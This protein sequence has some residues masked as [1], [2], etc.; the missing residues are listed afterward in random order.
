MGNALS[1]LNQQ[2]QES[3]ICSPGVKRAVEFYRDGSNRVI[4]VSCWSDGSNT[5]CVTE[6]KQEEH[7]E[8]VC[9]NTIESGGEELFDTWQRLLTSPEVGYKAR[10]IN[11]EE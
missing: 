6:V 2:C 10:I 11:I 8:N 9:C 1:I 5:S 4:R 3:G 7:E